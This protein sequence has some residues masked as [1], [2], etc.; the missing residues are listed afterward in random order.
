MMMTMFFKNLVAPPRTSSTAYL[1]LHARIMSRC[2]RLAYLQVRKAA[3]RLALVNVVRANVDEVVAALHWTLVLD[4]F[5]IGVVVL[6]Y[7]PALL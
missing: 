7:D 2:R 4:K 3:C 6:L 1:D 5:H